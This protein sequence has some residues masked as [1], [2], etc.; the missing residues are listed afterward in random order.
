MITFDFSNRVAV[1]TGAGGGIGLAI[2]QRIQASGGAVLMIDVKPR[3]ADIVDSDH[4]LYAQGDLTDE[5]FVQAAV[6]GAAAKFGRSVSANP[7][8][9]I[10]RP[11]GRNHE[12]GIWTLRRT[13]HLASECG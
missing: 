3:P 12:R 8:H 4:C 2:A 5:G 9:K 7:R 13:S 6:N 1:V 11:I 10:P